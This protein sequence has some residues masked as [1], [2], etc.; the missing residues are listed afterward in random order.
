MAHWSAFTTRSM[1]RCAS[2]K[3]GRPVPAPRLSTVRAPEALQKGASLDPQW[4]DA[5]KKVPARKRHI[6]VDTLV[7]MLSVFVYPAGIQRFPP[8][9]AVPVWLATLCVSG[10]V[11]GYL[12]M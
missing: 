6:L 5:G 12:R 4:Y 10:W 2:A 9:R 11:S 3:D 1:W 7:L 8:Q